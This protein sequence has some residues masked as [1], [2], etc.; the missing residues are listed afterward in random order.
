MT[1]PHRAHTLK[2]ASMSSYDRDDPYTRRVNEQRDREGQ[3][4]QRR[5]EVE[6]ARIQGGVGYGRYGSAAQRA[7]QEAESCRDVVRDLIAN[8]SDPLATRQ[9]WIAELD[10]I[11]LSSMLAS[12]WVQALSAEIQRTTASPTLRLMVDLRMYELDLACRSYQRS[13]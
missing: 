6:M 12:R 7:L 9:Q 11:T 2:E 5:H 13:R 8:S 10:G 4:A 3:E 1:H